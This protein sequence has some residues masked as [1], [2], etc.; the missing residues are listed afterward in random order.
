MDGNYNFSSLNTGGGFSNTTT[1]TTGFSEN[2]LD[3]N[4]F[5]RAA[6]APLISQA[7]NLNPINPI[8]PNQPSLGYS[9]VGSFFET[10][11]ITLYVPISGI[12]AG[13]HRF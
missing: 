13:H 7:T 2:M 5:G 3:T 10:R 8:G 12:Y 4:F 6:T 1:T 9:Q 11:L